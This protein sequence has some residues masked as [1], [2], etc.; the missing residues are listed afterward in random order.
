MNTVKCIFHDNRNT[1]ELFKIGVFSIFMLNSKVIM[2]I[3]LT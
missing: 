3:N 2:K 1:L